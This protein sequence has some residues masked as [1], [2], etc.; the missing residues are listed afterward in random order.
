MLHFIRSFVGR[1]AAH[2]VCEVCES[3][4]RDELDAVI[5]ALMLDPEIDTDAD[6][7][8]AIVRAREL[9]FRFR[10]EFFDYL[11]AYVPA[12]V[13]AGLDVALVIHD[14]DGTGSG[15]CAADCSGCEFERESG[16]VLRYAARIEVGPLPFA[17]VDT[18]TGRTLR[19]FYAAEDAERAASLLNGTEAAR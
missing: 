15:A 10:S 9:A 3:G 6:P 1:L 17:V 16:A 13:P 19:K 14:L 11:G 18:E 12:A 5:D 8:E 7:W 4:M 2:R